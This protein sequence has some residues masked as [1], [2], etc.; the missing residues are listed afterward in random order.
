MYNP[1]GGSAKHKS[2]QAVKNGKFVIQGAL[3]FYKWAKRYCTKITYSHILV[4]DYENSGKFLRV[5]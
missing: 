5:V 1:I 3:D 4:E 2:D